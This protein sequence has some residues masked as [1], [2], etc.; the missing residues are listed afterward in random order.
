MTSRPNFSAL[1]GVV[2]FFFLAFLRR[3]PFFLQEFRFA[4]EFLIGKKDGYLATTGIV[5]G[6]SRA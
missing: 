5:N 2:A 1:V 6:R 4:R 3:L